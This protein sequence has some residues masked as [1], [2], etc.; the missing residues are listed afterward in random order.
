MRQT[1]GFWWAAYSFIKQMHVK[2]TWKRN[3]EWYKMVWYP[4]LDTVNT[5]G[6]QRM[7]KTINAE[8]K[9]SEGARSWYLKNVYLLR[10]RWGQIR[11]QT[12]SEKTEA[13]IKWCRL[14][15]N[16]LP[17]DSKHRMTSLNTFLEANSV[18]KERRSQN[19][20]V[21]IK[22]LKSKCFFFWELEGK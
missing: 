16:S 17:K 4:N 3:R 8:Q 20:I 15:D 6:I 7:E 18:A 13:Q 22:S 9:H 21:Q 1:L 11:Y 12:W 19:Q 2:N 10:G 5:V 14:T